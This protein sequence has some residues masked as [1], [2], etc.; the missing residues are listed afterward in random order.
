MYAADLFEF[1]WV[2]AIV[3]RYPFLFFLL[4]GFA[5]WTV[6][7]SLESSSADKSLVVVGHAQIEK[8]KKEWLKRHRQH[9]TPQ[10]LDA[11]VNMYVEDELLVRQAVSMGIAAHDPVVRMR[12]YKNLRFLNGDEADES[13]VKIQQA[14]E[15]GMQDKDPVV[16]R[17]LIQVMEEKIRSSF[18]KPAYTE[19][20]L[21]AYMSD[22]RE[23][24]QEPAKWTFDHLLFAQKKDGLEARDRAER[25]LQ[26][27][28]ATASLEDLEGVA[29]NSLIPR[30]FTNSTQKHVERYLGIRFV[31]QLESSPTTTPQ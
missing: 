9:A 24:Y 22:H 26:T 27:I 29:D 20:T 7:D 25:S 28:A 10:E 11:L 8:I 1:Q 12:L 16:R 6:E 15:M 2:F 5:I 21:L 3:L 14:V 30:H 4:I 19:Q 13:E 17:R 31:A 18:K 23:R